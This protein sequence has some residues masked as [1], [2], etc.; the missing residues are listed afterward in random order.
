MLPGDALATLPDA[1]AEMEER[2]RAELAAEGLEGVAQRT[3]DMRYRRQGYEL[4]VPWDAQAPQRT[5]QAFHQLHE[6]LYG[7]SDVARSVEIVNLR[8]RMVAAG[9]PYEPVQ[10]KLVPGDGSTA[11]FAQRNVFFDGQFLSTRF[12]RRDGLHPG[13]VIRGPAMI[14]EYT[15][16]TVLPPGATALVDGFDN[17]VINFEEGPQ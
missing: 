8:L 4:N 10:S 7:F 15:A 14:T 9:E 3:V 13:D 2:G 1:F 17:L 11:C 5:V 16:A 6:Q 12:Y